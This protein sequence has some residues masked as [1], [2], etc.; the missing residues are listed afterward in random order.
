MKFLKVIAALALSVLVYSSCNNDLKILAPYKDITVV[1]GLLDQNDPVHYF[2]INKGFLGNGNAYTMAMQ[3]DSIYYPV[4]NIHAY[5]QD[6]STITNTIVDTF[7]LD[8]IT[9]IPLN[10]GT[11][12]YPKQLLYYT[13]AKNKALNPNDYYNL[14]VVNT[15]T[16][17]RITGST[18]ILPDLSFAYPTAN[19][20]S[21]S[22]I[23]IT[24]DNQH[25][26]TIAWNSSVNGRIYQMDIKFNFDEVTT[27][28]D[29][30]YYSLDWLFNP[31]TCSSLAGNV[32]MQYQFTAQGLMTLI[33]NSL[34]PKLGVVRHFQY[35]DV[36]FTTGSDDLN[37][38][39]L[40]SQ[41]PTGINQDVPSFTD[42]K[43]GVG[44]FTSRHVETLKKQLGATDLDSLQYGSIT[45]NL[46]FQP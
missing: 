46:G 17:K 9:T 33:A 42:L 21:I 14:V 37:T 36:I 23:N 2:R 4:G 13:T 25:P 16:G 12:S 10:P 31:L 35:L 34:Q 30:S 40:L 22:T 32:A 6:S 26:T 38:Y 39:V 1:Y 29:T 19:F 11:F 18:N 5:L 43:N 44:L 20:A 3:Y 24:F 27:A 41:P 7:N 8:T 15:K 28:G 45:G